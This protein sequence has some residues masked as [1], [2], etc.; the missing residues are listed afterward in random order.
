MTRIARHLR[1]H[2]PRRWTDRDANEAFVG[3]ALVALLLVAAWSWLE[4]GPHD[5][6]HDAPHMGGVTDGTP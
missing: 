3:I 1:E 5:T 2:P 6:A 4:A